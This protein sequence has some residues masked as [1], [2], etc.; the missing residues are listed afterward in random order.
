MA[1]KIG[2]CL[3]EVDLTLFKLG[4]CSFLAVLLFYL[5]AIGLSS[6]LAALLAFLMVIGLQVLQRL[7]I[8]VD[9]YGILLVKGEGTDSPRTVQSMEVGVMEAVATLGD[10][11]RN[12]LS[13]HQ[14]QHLSRVW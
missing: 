10:Q 4:P 13:C 1:K 14:R 5:L 9:L 8:T 2:T 7:N 11:R 6:S 12:C 3:V